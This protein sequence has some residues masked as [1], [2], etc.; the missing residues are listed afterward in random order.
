MN[1]LTKRIVL[2]SSCL[3][4]AIILIID[5][6]GTVSICSGE[7]GCITTV[8]TI[9]I[10]FLPALPLAV[11]SILVYFLRDEVFQSW[12][13]FALWWIPLSM[14]FTLVFQDQHGQLISS[15]KQ[16]VSFFMAVLFTAISLTLIIYKSRQLRQEI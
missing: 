13:R 7:S 12:I 2:V 4:A 10:I 9:G 8:A 5:Y 1:I 3:I 16:M 14:L 11:I 6:L 15:T